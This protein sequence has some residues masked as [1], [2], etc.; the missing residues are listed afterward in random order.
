MA[1]ITRLV[2]WGYLKGVRNPQGVLT[3]EG[4]CVWNE[5]A[6]CMKGVFTI[7]VTFLR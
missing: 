4:V 5:S 1:D 7:K 3:I 2:I 6:W